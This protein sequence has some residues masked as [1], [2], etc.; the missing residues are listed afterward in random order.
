[1][2]LLR[3]VIDAIGGSVGGAVIG[4]R[5]ALIAMSVNKT[6]SPAAPSG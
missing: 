4:F 5:V 2:I 1:M 3:F 6:P